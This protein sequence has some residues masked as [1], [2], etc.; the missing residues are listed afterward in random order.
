MR[1]GHAIAAHLL[2]KTP[3]RVL[4]L[5]PSGA[6]RLQ[7]LACN[8]RLSDAR[9]SPRRLCLQHMWR[10]GARQKAVSHRELLPVAQLLPTPP[11]PLEAPRL[12]QPQSCR[13]SSRTLGRQLHC[14][15]PRQSRAAC[16]QSGLKGWATCRRAHALTLCGWHGAKCEQR[17]RRLRVCGASALLQISQHEISDKGRW[18]AT[19]MWRLFRDQ[20]HHRPI[21]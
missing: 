16:I 7:Q 4:A 20:L 9:Q 5:S 6:Q 14:L 12:C 13:G 10:G 1:E 11:P 2:S 3:T 21:L 19:S 18:Q 15:A 17:Q 8:L